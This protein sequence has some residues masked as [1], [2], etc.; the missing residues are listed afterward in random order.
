MS[1]LKN[2]FKGSE[3][4]ILAPVSGEAVSIKEVNDPTFSE[5]ILGKGI[6][7]RP[8]EGK[9]VAPCDGIIGMMFDTGHAVSMTADCGAEVLVH[10]G[11]ETVGLKGKFFKVHAKDG[12]HVKAGQLLI[13]FDPEGIKNAGYDLI[14]P[15]VICN[16]DDFASVNPVAG[17]K[18]AA[19]DKIIGIEKK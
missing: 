19:G 15:I 13:E 7:I 16:T 12:D 10:V 9:I 5:E 8:R 11:L 2:L 18:V 17:G 3:L 6:A 1:F 4:E 14:T